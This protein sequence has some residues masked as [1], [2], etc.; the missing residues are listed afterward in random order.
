MPGPDLD[1]TNP[2]AAHTMQ[3]LPCPVQTMPVTA[4]IAPSLC[5]TQSMPVL[6]KTMP[7]TSTP[8]A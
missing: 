1:R 8:H 4:Q 5:P 7:M 6:A 2:S 3:G